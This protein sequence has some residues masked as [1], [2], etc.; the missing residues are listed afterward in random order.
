M[1]TEDYDETRASYEPSAN[2]GRNMQVAI[3]PE[4]FRMEHPQN[5]AI[6]AVFRLLEAFDIGRHEWVIDPFEVDDFVSF[7][8]S[9]FPSLA[10]TYASMARLAS[11]RTA[12]WTGGDQRGAV[13][14]DTTSLVDLAADLS[15]PAVVV[16]EDLPSDGDRFLGTLIEVFGP[17]R[18]RGAYRE[19]WLEVVH[20]GGTGRMPAVAAAAAKRFRSWSESSRFWTAID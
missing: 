13:R 8:P 2:G 17:E 18:L 14:V 20:S 5:A 15:Q 7:A 3:E 19:R 1:F 4:V 16:V 11:K 12:A 10:A 9:H 6:G